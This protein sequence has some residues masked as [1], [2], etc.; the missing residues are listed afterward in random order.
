MESLGA[1]RTRKTW[2]TL[3]MLRAVVVLVGLT[4]SFPQLSHHHPTHT[5]APQARK[6]SMVVVDSVSPE[7]P[8]LVPKPQQVLEGPSGWNN[9]PVEMMHQVSRA[10][11]WKTTTMRGGE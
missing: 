10:S 9:L 6:Q 3:M 2:R 8:P 7:P 5:L 4:R 1:Q 11:R